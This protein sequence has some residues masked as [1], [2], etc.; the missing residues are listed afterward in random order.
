MTSMAAALLLAATLN[1]KVSLWGAATPIAQVEVEL[2]RV[3]GPPR[4]IVTVTGNDGAFRI[5]NVPPGKYRLIAMR[6]GFTQGEYRQR[7]PGGKGEPITIKDGETIPLVSLAMS[8]G[9]TISGRV[10]DR[11]GKPARSYVQAMRL[12]YENGKPKLVIEQAIT[13]DDRGMYRMFWLAPGAYYVM[14]RPVVAGIGGGAIVN[15]NGAD[16]S[17]SMFPVRLSNVARSPRPAGLDEGEYFLATYYPGTS[18]LQSASLVNVRAGEEIRD[19]NMN[20][21]AAKAVTLRVA[22]VDA[23]GAEIK[24]PWVSIE[25]VLDA[26]ILPGPPPTGTAFNNVVTFPRVLPGMYELGG[27]EPGNWGKGRAVIEV[28]DRDVD[29]TITLADFKIDGHVYIDRPPQGFELEKQYV[30]LRGSAGYENTANIAAD[31]AFH[32]EGVPFGE[33]QVLVSDSALLQMYVAGVRV[34]STEVP[35]GNLRVNAPIGQ[36]LNILLSGNGGEV[37]GVVPQFPVATVVLISPSVVKTAIADA[38]GRFQIS[39]VAPGEYSVY[40]F[41]DI[42]PGAWF[43]RNYM[44]LFRDLAQTVRVAAGQKVNV[45]LRGIP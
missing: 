39:G 18:Q 19:V 29:V 21:I 42:E 20:L 44:A 9:G 25:P 13:T 15:P 12:S 4:P 2:R 5:S 3:E 27:S 10:L 43:D 17:I 38:N 26:G 28:I 30:I 37:S 7:R 22:V 24:A 34:G 33:Y 32:L 11:A 16:T 35:S 6:P 40:A 8:P 41:A 14:F 23:A 1:G 45:Q 36:P 31:G